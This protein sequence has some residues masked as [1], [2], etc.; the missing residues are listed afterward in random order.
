MGF[1]GPVSFD[2]AEAT[3]V[4]TGLKGP[5]F[6]SVSVAGKAQNY[7]TGITLTRDPD[8]VGGLMVDVMGWTG[9]IGQG[10][11]P[12]EVENHFPGQ[13]FP[14]IFVKGHNKI[15][16]V[17]VEQIPYQKDDSHLKERALSKARIKA[18]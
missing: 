13:F 7:T 12:Y 1:Y 3:Y 8:F 4:W 16:R 14:E 10:T 11:T 17:K 2:T 6:Y 9:P 5:G 18:A 15:E